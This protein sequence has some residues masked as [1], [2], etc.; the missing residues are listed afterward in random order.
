M[1]AAI[2]RVLLHADHRRLFDLFTDDPPLQGEYHIRRSF[3][4][5]DVLFPAHPASAML[6]ADKLLLHFPSAGGAYFVTCT[7]CDLPFSNLSVQK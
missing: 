2:V 5:S 4:E 7:H 6:Q 1:R 3:K